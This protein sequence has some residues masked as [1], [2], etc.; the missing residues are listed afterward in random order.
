MK[1]YSNEEK[2]YIAQNHLVP[3]LLK[4]YQIDNIGLNFS[5]ELLIYIIENYTSEAGVRSLERHIRTI[6]E[7]IISYKYLTK[8]VPK[9][10]DVNVFKKI[11]STSYFEKKPQNSIRKSVRKKQKGRK[12]VYNIDL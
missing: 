4:E 9:T 2:S 5:T 11:M 1:G 8:K 6:C 3:S 10:I 7:T 12:K